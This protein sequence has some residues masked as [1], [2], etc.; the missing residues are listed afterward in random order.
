[1]LKNIVMRVFAP[2]AKQKIHAEI[3]EGDRQRSLGVA[4]SLTRNHTLVSQEQ[5]ILRGDINR[6]WKRRTP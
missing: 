3:D 6:F 1:M 2:N 4:S 5:I